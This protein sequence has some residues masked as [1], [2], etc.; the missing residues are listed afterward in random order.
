MTRP[1]FHLIPHT[2]WDR[3]W[4]LTRAALTVRLAGALDR[5]VDLLQ[6]DGAL[7][8]HLDGQAILIEDYL[9]VRPAARWRVAGLVGA[10]RLVIGP[11]YLLADEL[12]PSG[13]SL[14][15]NL[16]VGGR[17]ARGLG[18]GCR[19]WYGPDA[20]GH[21]AG[22]PRI[23][24][25]FGLRGGVVWR[26]TGGAGTGGRD[27]FRWTAGP[28]CSLLSL[29]LPPDGYEVGVDLVGEPGQLAATWG[30]LRPT[31]EA[32][33]A[34]D[35][36]AVPIGA[37]HHAPSDRLVGLVDRLAAVDRTAT[38]RCSTLDEYFEAVR[39]AIGRDGGPTAGPRPLAAVDGELRRADRHTWALQGVHATRARMKRHHGAAELG[40]VRVAEPVVALSGV[41]SGALEPA[42]RALLETQFHDTLAGTCADSV[43]REA[44]ARLAAVR[45][46]SRELFRLG[47]DRLVG[48]DPDLVREQP[49]AAQSAAVVWNPAARSRSGVAIVETTWFRE[50]VLV[51]PPGARVPSRG[52]GAVPFRFT[53]RD[54]VTLPSQLLSLRPGLERIDAA[55][56]Y[57]DLDQVD[58]MFVAVEL[59]P[60]GGLAASVLDATNGTSDAPVPVGGHGATPPEAGRRS[61]GMRAPIG[62]PPVPYPV[63]P[64][65]RGWGLTNGLVSIAVDR[66]GR[67]TLVDQVRGQRYP[68]VGRLEARSDDGDCYTPQLGARRWGARMT[69]IETVAPG[70]LIG[71]VAVRWL[72]D[73]PNGT[74]TGRTIATIHAGSPAVRIRLELDNQATNHRLAWS[75]T[76]GARGAA[77]AGTAHGVVRRPPG[78]L[79]R[80]WEP[81]WGL[82]T[83][84]AQRF[85]AVASGGRGLAILQ[86]GFFEYQWSADGSLATTLLRSVGELSRGDL[87]ARRGHAGWITA[88][89]EAQEPG[90]HVIELAVL[91]I[92]AG[93]LA[94]P[95]ALVEAWE[96]VFLPPIPIWHRRASSLTATHGLELVGAGLALEAVKPAEN[97][98][99]I[100]LRVVNLGQETTEG[101]WRAGG[102]ILRAERIRADELVSGPRAPEAA[103]GAPPANHAMPEPLSVEPDR[104]SVRFRARPGEIVSIRVTLDLES[105]RR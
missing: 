38:F 42:W 84:P 99:G 34:T 97:G 28:E 13:E 16:L 27:L 105:L 47:L 90:R 10:G 15:R 78:H 50:D 14:I 20:F 3:E 17:V 56:H 76:S 24:A 74:V 41:D 100:V 19:V 32:R 80:S 51:G 67:L 69:G 45:D 96:D 12:I 1:T 23:A 73:L 2:H 57:P 33:A 22:G 89:P 79:D 66:R 55:R 29:H 62:R 85:V 98:D 21:P 82:P 11:W 8:F 53:D 40:L 54:G 77:V 39:S 48:H 61:E 18:G 102:P 46:A 60:I 49:A 95:V 35:H 104:R 63:S 103:T 44:T 58:R 70:P 5:V 59:P 92:D 52:A 43:T 94:N 93:I 101:L 83:D 64:A 81:E 30:R 7:R 91:P 88:T 65:P 25:E 87:T 36:I 31:L 68:E 37:D 72:L 71:G 9:T 4:Y 86:P 6:R 75:V 26:G